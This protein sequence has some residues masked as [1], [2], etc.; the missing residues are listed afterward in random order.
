MDISALASNMAQMQTQSRISTAVAKKTLD[1]QK[2]QG[3]AA[4]KL[5]ESA[6]DVGQAAA[7]TTGVGAA[8]DVRG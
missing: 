3:E 1:S 5:L 7:R 4:I 8:V 6:M 2:Q